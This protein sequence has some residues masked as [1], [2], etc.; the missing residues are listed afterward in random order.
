MKYWPRLKAFS[1]P[2]LGRA[3]PQAEGAS[4]RG[5]SR[6][7]FLP[8]LWPV[9][10]VAAGLG[11]WAQNHVCDWRCE[12]EAAGLGHGYACSCP[13]PVCPWAAESLRLVILSGT[14]DAFCV[15]TS[16]HPALQAPE[17]AAPL[18]WAGTPSSLL[19]RAPP[20]AGISWPWW[21]SL[22]PW[23]TSMSHPGPPFSVYP[24]GLTA[25]LSSHIPR[26]THTFKWARRFSG[27]HQKKQ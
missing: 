27:L 18:E 3:S 19:N 22:C 11:G 20:R 26:G 2:Q 7:S 4:C 6:S 12:N 25:V 5:G 9:L 23:G 14:C 21:P 13:H 24:S 10:V 17:K 15:P 8:K 16:Q 1:L